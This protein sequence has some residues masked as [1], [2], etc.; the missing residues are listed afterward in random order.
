M[1]QLDNRHSHRGG[2]FRMR[3]RQRLSQRLVYLPGAL[4]LLYGFW[5]S[6]TA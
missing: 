4:V 1:F 3:Q 6:L 5:L 2:N